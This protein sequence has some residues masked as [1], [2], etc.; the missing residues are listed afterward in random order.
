[1]S[2]SPVELPG[3]LWEVVAAN[4]RERILSGEL[5]PGSKLVET[6][7]AEGFGTSRGPVR[8][9]IR[10]LARE[11][12]VAELSRRG[13]FVST[14]TVHDLSEVY[15]IREALEL[16]ACKPAIARAGNEELDALEEHLVAF[17][18]SWGKDVTYL[19]SA[20]HDLAFHR[21][22]LAL[23]G[24]QRMAAIYDQMLAQT[25]LLLRAAAEDNPQ[26]RAEMRAS[27][28]RDILDA[29]R[30]RDEERARAAIDAHYRYAEE[31]LFGHGP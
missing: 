15:A 16:S 27:A 22:F 4:I 6:E 10:E 8:E 7:L 30:A 20:V 24:N 31:R 9:A 5:A 2:D 29:L 21:A 25:M 28:H 17:E 18:A 3:P 14:L 1:V 11:G 12:L 23:A 19:E 13:T 26:L